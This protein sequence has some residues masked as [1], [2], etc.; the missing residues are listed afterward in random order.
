LNFLKLRE[1]LNDLA[2]R[3]SLTSLYVF[4]SQAHE[5]A[6]CLQRSI[7]STLNPETDIDIGVQPIPGKILTA[8]DRVEITLTLEELFRIQRVDL[9]VLSEAAP[10]LALDIIK[11]ELIYCK[12]PDRQAEDELY[13]LRRAGDLAYY[14]RQRRHLIIDGE[15]K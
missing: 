15:F 13:I 1:T 6:L 5:V 14:E 8:Q 10:F 2:D 11:G 3:Y 9:V 4:G 12:D 7:L